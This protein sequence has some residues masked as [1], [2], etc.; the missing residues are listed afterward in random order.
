MMNETKKITLLNVDANAKTIKGQKKGYMTAILYLAPFKLSGYQVCPMAELAGCVADCLNT[1]GRGG[2]ARADADTVTVDGM[3]VKLNAIQKA[4]IA[5]TRFFFEDREAFM[6]QL[7]NEIAKAKKLATKKNLELVV[8]LNGTSDIR[9]EDVI[10]ANGKT[11]F[12]VFPAIQFYDYTKIP[13]RNI[14]GIKNYHLTFSYSDRPEY[15]K[16][17]EKAIAFYGKTVNLAVVFKGKT[18]P[19]TFMGREV[20]SA[21]ESDL[22]FLD[23]TNGI[24]GLIAKGNAKKSTSGFCVEAA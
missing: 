11:I 8:R 22:R 4:R 17:V 23:P 18:L 9:F 2:M 16:I 10:V 5:R 3:T 1:A 6:V 12:E 21:D 19:K 20:F 15:R 24:A 14:A 7:C 13:N